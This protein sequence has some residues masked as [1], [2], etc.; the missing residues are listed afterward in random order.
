VSKENVTVRIPKA[1]ADHVQK[2]PWFKMDCS[3][4]DF[5]KEATREH[6]LKLMRIEA[7]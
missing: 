1:T 4:E 5:V 3:L 6:L 2:Q 7:K